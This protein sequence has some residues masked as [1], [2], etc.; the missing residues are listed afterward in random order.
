MA[1]LIKQD[2]GLDAALEVGERGELSVWVNDRKVAAKDHKGFPADAQLVALV[3]EA[4]AA[5]P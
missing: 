4:V 2:T 3:R 5:Q 1:A